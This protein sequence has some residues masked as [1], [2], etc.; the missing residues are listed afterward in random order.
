MTRTSE[1][2][3]AFF[4]AL[5]GRAQRSGAAGLGAS[6]RAGRRMVNV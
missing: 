4:A 5:S 2:L 6:I 3:M 1:P